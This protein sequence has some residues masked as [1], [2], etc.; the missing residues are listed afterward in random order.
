MPTPHRRG[1][2]LIIS[3]AM[4]TWAFLMAWPHPSRA[5]PSWLLDSE[6]WKVLASVGAVAISLLAL[7]VTSIITRAKT[8]REKRDELKTLI[9]KLI[10][11]RNEFNTTMPKFTSDVEREAYSVL[12]NS[13]KAIYLESAEYLAKRVRHVT[14]AE[15]RVLGGEYQMD[16]NFSKAESL[17]ARAVRAA[18]DT[19]LASRSAALQGFAGAAMMQGDSGQ[20]RARDAFQQVTDALSAQRD[21]YSIYLLA[22]SFRTWASAEFG[23]GN[24]INARDRLMDSLRA[25]RQIPNWSGLRPIELRS[26][27]RGLGDVFDRFV[28]VAEWDAARAFFNDAAAVIRS[29]SDEASKEML[30]QIYWR[31]AWLEFTTDHP[32]EF[33]KFGQQARTVVMMLPEANQTRIQLLAVL[34]PPRLAAVPAPNPAG[35]AAS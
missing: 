16:S 25:V 11:L 10:D 12:T 27:A 17:F 14:S 31:L 32:D 18:R 21:P 13:K 4:L 15:W 1:R 23:V 28:A 9:E 5:S 8:A 30:G 7:V 33:E 34:P 29:D 22:F 35:T 2:T 19:S 24:L 3:S 26:C 6:T 20:K